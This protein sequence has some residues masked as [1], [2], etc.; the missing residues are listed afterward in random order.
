[1][2]TTTTIGNAP[3]LPTNWL[4]TLFLIAGVSSDNSYSAGIDATTA[5]ALF[6]YSGCWHQPQQQWHRWHRHSVAAAYQW[7]D[8]TAGRM[9][10]EYQAILGDQWRRRRQQRHWQQHSGAA[11][12]RATGKMT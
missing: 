4:S 9:T 11:A 10:V 8:M 6:S 5:S 1:M 3:V 12:T 2:I 7:D